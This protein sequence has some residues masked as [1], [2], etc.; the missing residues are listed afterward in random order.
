MGDEDPYA[1]CIRKL[2][3]HFRSDE[4]IPFERHVFRQ[5]APTDGESVDKFVVRLR[6]Q[7]RF[8]YFGGALDDNLTARHRIEK[9]A[10]GNQKHYFSTS[11]G[12]KESF[13]SGGTTSE[14]HG[15]CIG[16]RRSRTKG[17]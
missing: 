7:A 17:G 12:E 5:L 2:D 4:N 13:G 14:A 3:H 10:V 15:G 8:C 9:E 16:R 11:F 6:Q 1:V